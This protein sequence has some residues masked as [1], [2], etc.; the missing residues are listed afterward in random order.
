MQT[1][2]I[3]SAWTTTSTLTQ[4]PT[5]IIKEYTQRAITT[6]EYSTIPAGPPH[7]VVE[8]VTLPASTIVQLATVTAQYVSTIISVSTVPAGPPQTVVIT[9][10]IPAETCYVT[11][12]FTSAYTTTVCQVFTQRLAR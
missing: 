12:S 11:K 5:T 8:T 1:Q 3:T 10:T 9:S 4:A 6:T 7:T 2:T